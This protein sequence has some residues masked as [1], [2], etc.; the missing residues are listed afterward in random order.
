M[1]DEIA[2]DTDVADVAVAPPFS[3]IGTRAPVTASGF[4][5]LMKVTLRSRDSPVGHQQPV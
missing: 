5:R 3:A 4:F 1:Y 2:D